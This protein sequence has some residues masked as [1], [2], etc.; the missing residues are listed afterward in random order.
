[1]YKTIKSLN[2]NCVLSVY[3]DT[4][5]EVILL[6]KGIG[7]GK[8][9][10]Q[11]IKINDQI[12]VY[13]LNNAKE[14]LSVE[15]V[16]AT[17]P[18]FIEISDAI[19]IET[20]KTFG[21]VNKEIILA[22]AD[23]IQF[24][25][26]RMEAKMEIANPFANDT[27]LL[28][29]KEYEVA[30]KAKKIIKGRTSHTINDDEVAFITLHIHLGINTKNTRMDTL[31]QIQYIIKDN[32]ELMK[33]KLGFSIDEKTIFYARLLNHLKFLIL[34]VENDEKL[35]INL[36]DYVEHSFPDSYRV[37]KKICLEF[38]K[39]FNKKILEAEVGYLAIHLERIKKDQLIDDTI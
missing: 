16:L 26:K 12:K 1:M 36:N 9:F 13:E 35:D 23:H 17:D 10:N 27:R 5:K 2:N 11:E 8:S 31:L 29:P 30:L 33:N 37:S 7:F 39:V 6:G 32:I 15:T 21:F 24:A 18:L 22:L 34:R 19:L 38:E 20:E 14:N 4:N 25:I 3:T 28:F